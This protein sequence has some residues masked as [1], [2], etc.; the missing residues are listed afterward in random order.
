MLK[1]NPNI[2]KVYLCLDNDEAGQKANERISDN[3][4]IQGIQ[5]ETLVPNH[6]DWNEDRLAADCNAPH[7]GAEFSVSNENEE[8][9]EEP[10]QVLQL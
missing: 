2:Q 1:D 4:F 5:H 3:L 8:E 10:C 9:G 7:H 6:K